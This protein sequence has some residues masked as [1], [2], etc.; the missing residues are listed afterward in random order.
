M[1]GKGKKKVLFFNDKTA[2]ENAQIDE[3]LVKYWRN[4]AV[5]GMDEAKIEDYLEKKSITSMKGGS[6]AAD[7]PSNPLYS[8]DSKKSRKSRNFKRHNDHIALQEYNPDL[9]VSAKKF[10][11]E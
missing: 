1:S 6:T 9:A 2:N 3:D 11:K 8:K 4:V 10:K 5:D 7:D